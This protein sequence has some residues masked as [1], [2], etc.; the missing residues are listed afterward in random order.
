MNKDELEIIRA[1]TQRDIRGAMDSGHWENALEACV[2]EI[3]RCWAM[4]RQWSR[5]VGV[6][7]QHLS[8]CDCQLC[9]VMQET[10]AKFPE[11]PNGNP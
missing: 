1:M 4:L 8:K 6:P 11:V 10:L 5:A 9:T 2:E 3:D 7:H